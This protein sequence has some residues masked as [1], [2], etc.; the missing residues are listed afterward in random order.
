MNWLNLP[1]PTFGILA[2]EGMPTPSPPLPCIGSAPLEAL[3]ASPEGQRWTGFEVPRSLRFA[4]A[5]PDVESEPVGWAGLDLVALATEMGIDVAAQLEAAVPGSVP[6]EG[7]SWTIDFELR[8]WSPPAFGPVDLCA[9]HNLN[10]DLPLG[11]TLNGTSFADCP[12]LSIGDNGLSHW[13]MAPE[14]PLSCSLPW[15]LD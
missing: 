5:D 12:A 1:G 4:G 13:L 15:H 8:Q 2:S 11:V 6:P 10:A 9:T 14:E 7:L 3:W